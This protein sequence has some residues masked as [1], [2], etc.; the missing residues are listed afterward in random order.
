MS[1]KP[2]RPLGMTRSNAPVPFL[3]PFT[4]RFTRDGENRKLVSALQH[5]KP[6]V[7][8]SSPAQYPHLQDNKKREW[9]SDS[10]SDKGLLQQL[11]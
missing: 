7:D 5:V 11:A 4:E 3:N 6:A 9:L 10:M 8:N 2:V 1:K